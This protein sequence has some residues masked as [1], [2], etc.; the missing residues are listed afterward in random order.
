MGKEEW[1]DEFGLAN[2]EKKASL[3]TLNKIP[4]NI[5]WYVKMF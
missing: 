5:N 1:Y 4:E 2:K 3:K